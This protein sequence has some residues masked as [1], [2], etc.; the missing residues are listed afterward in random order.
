MGLYPSFSAVMLSHEE[1]NDVEDVARGAIL[2][3]AAV[4]LVIKDEIIITDVNKND[5]ALFNFFPLEFIVIPP[6]LS[7]NLH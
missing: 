3:S 7:I 4:L 5:S 1:Q 6:I 2:V